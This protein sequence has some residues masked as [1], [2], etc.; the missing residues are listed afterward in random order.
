M[1]CLQR[2]N[3]D[4]NAT[5]RRHEVELA[6]HSAPKVSIAKASAYGKWVPKV[7]QLTVDVEF[8]LQRGELLMP[9]LWKSRSGKISIIV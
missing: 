3:K 1:Q 8:A 4:A 9:R 5:Q 7:P 2:R 6:P